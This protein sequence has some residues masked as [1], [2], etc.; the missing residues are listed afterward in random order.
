[1]PEK[2]VALVFLFCNL[3]FTIVFTGLAAESSPESD[4]SSPNFE[5]PFLEYLLSCYLIR[6][7]PC[8]LFCELTTKVLCA[9]CKGSSSQ[10][11]RKACC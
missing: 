9:S 11:S 6:S 10:Y 8:D 2:L 5:T 1:M 4:G 7:F 3:V